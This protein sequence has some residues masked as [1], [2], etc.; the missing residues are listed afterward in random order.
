MGFLSAAGTDPPRE[1]SAPRRFT[2]ILLASL[3]LAVVVTLPTLVARPWADQRIYLYM[4]ERMVGS[5]PALLVREVWREIPGYLDAGVFRPVSR[6]A[7]HLDSWLTVRTALATGL[8]P[9]CVQGAVKVAMLAALLSVWLATLGQYRRAAGV[10]ADHPRFRLLATLLAV[11]AAAS[12]VV[13]TPSSHPLT[14][15]PLLYLGTT[16]LALSLPL[17]LGRSLQRTS[18]PGLPGSR[19]GVLPLLGFAL[20]GALP[21]A[22]LELAYLAVPLALVH[23]TLL[24]FASGCPAPQLVRRLA[25][26]GVWHRWL[27]LT[28]GFLS[29]FIPTRILI[30]LHCSGGDCYEAATLSFSVDFF[31]AL[32][33]RAVAGFFPIP[34]AAR[35]TGLAKGA[36]TPEFWAA[37]ALAALLAVA[38]LWTALRR[39]RVGS[40]ERHPLPRTMLVAFA[41][42]SAAVVVLAAALA[43]LSRS[44]QGRS[45]GA[46]AAGSWRETGFSWI[47]WVGLLTV[48]AAIMLTTVKRPLA[49]GLLLAGVAL[50]VAAASLQNQEQMRFAQSSTESLLQL[51]VGELLVNFDPGTTGN[52]ERC[53]VLAELEDLAATAS[54]KRKMALLGQ[55]LDATAG[56]HYGTPFCD[57]G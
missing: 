31:R 30:A 28:A 2:L 45:L 7:L 27:A 29:L 44:M 18:G 33:F 9:A 42:Y 22:M 13:P 1:A 26:S 11:V 24:L 5:N 47:G 10:P 4:P 49:L 8:T 36:L 43:A 38:L 46:L 17:I 3:A 15:F 50:A 12:L 35:A 23:P 16:A 19:P 32:P 41:L 56:N 40:P 39:L 48:V 34:H 52:E 51:R 14:L 21:A 37:A 53:R 57:P 55:L 54:E 20:L 25:T 6:L